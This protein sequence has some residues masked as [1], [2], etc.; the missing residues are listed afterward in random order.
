SLAVQ[1]ALAVAVPLVLLLT[2]PFDVGSVD[3]PLAALLGM[4]VGLVLFAQMEPFNA[5]GPL[6]QRVV[7]FL[8]GAVGLLGLYFGLK[9][10]F[11]DEGEPF[12]VPLRIVRYALVGVW[13]SLGGPWLFVRLN[14]SPP[15]VV[16]Q[17]GGL[18]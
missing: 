6:W 14:L 7:R 17:E 11:P 2:S 3:T 5:G 4:G 18:S 10:V 12:Y 16:E 8:V 9:A 1:L 15:P 13:I